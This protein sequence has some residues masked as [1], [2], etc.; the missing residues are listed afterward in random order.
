VNS[1]RESGGSGSASNGP[2]CVSSGKSSATPTASTS[3]SGTG[4]TSTDGGTCASPPPPTSAPAISSREGSHA[5]TCRSRGSKG[6]S[7]QATAVGCGEKCTGSCASCDPVGYSLRTSLGSELTARTGCSVTW[8]RRA[9]PAGRSWWVL[10]MSAPP[11][12]ATASG[13]S[14]AGTTLTDATVRMWPTPQTPSQGG[15]SV[16]DESQCGQ[17][18]LEEAVRL[19]GWNTPRARDWKGDGTNSLHRQVPRSTSGK[20][21]ARLNARWVAQLLGF[22]HDWLAPDGRRN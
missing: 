11:T 5:R 9:T 6:A 17:V 15:R 12:D 4:H 3:L 21:R 1:S 18:H 20:R 13:S 2:A 7:K 8:K 22:P 19:Q 14:D 10:A 16:T